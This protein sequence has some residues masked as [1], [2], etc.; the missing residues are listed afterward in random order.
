MGKDTFL[1]SWKNT[2]GGQFGRTYENSN[3]EY[4]NLESIL[5][6][7]SYI[8]LKMHLIIEKFIAEFFIKVGKK[9]GSD[10]NP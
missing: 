9:P 6:E 2:F 4:L 5:K 3:Q 8:C 7:N 1:P 10:M